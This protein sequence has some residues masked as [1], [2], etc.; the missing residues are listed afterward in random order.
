LTATGVLTPAG[1]Q[2]APQPIS[3][4]TLDTITVTPTKTPE[5]IWDSLSSTSA[6]RQDKI[7]QLMPNRTSDLLFGLP[8]VTQVTRGDD[9]ATAINIRGL[10]DFGRVAVVVDGARQNFQRSGHNANG[11]FYL[12][13]ELISGLDITRGPVANIYG[14]GAIGG[15]AS[16]TTKDANDILKPGERW[17]I[18]TH[19]LGGTNGPLGLSSVFAAARPNE[20]VDIFAGGT[21][22]SS[23]DY[24]DGHGDTVANTG[25][26]IWTGIGKITV[27]PADG[28]EVKLGA[29]HYD[30]DY[31]TGQSGVSG[32]YG[33]NVKN[34]QL[35]GKYT[36][37]PTGQSLIDLAT[38]I[39]FNRSSTDQTVKEQFISGGID[40]TGPVGTRRNF[41]IDTKGFDI[42]NTSRFDWGPFR[43][44]LTVGGDGFRD[45]VSISSTGDPGSALTPG[46]TRKVS[47]AFVQWKANYSTWLE[48]IGALRYDNYSLDGGGTHTDG[49]RL[50]PKIT[51][52]V[53]PIAGFQPYV[54]YAEGYRAPA[55]TETLVVGY[56]PGDLFYF[57]P[58]PNLRPEI[59]KT[60]EAGVNLKYDNLF[61][62][63]DKFRGKI[64]IFRNNVEDYIDLTSF[65]YFG[66]PPAPCPPSSIFGGAGSLCFQY[67]NVPRA[68]VEGIEFE[69]M[70][71]AGRW[72][73][74]LAGQH[75]K[76][77]NLTNSE[78]LA[79]IQPDSLTTTLGA[80]F[81]DRKLTVAMRWMAVAPKR[82]GDI[83]VDTNQPGNP[84][85]FPTS[86][87]YNL[88][89]LY[90]GYEPKPD[91]QLGFSIDNLLDE[92]YTPYMNQLSEPGIT[93]KGELKVRFSDA[94]FKK[95]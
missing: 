3:T 36:Y 47:G 82:A 19:G 17:A 59:G 37:A 28:H 83:P 35:T 63:G 27:R 60:S 67:T 71:D 61:T 5:N 79:T 87:A 49:D 56:H 24:R 20:N 73:A 54:T 4:I 22:R 86:D 34:D 30:A 26:D 39:Y 6:V 8:S 78:P 21:Y 43:N 88:V 90:V 69:T 55:V 66:P 77:R 72:F 12:E 23:G 91:V 76:G 84:L 10:Q 57:L 1:A 14:S 75:L 68:R 89:K 50:S 58:N 65:A 2:D 94:Y 41:T 13:P 80:R 11:M 81:L 15:V 51:V 92:K 64:S 85:V 53:T 52:G 25:Q 95:G 44:A 74:G 9:P 45:D 38:S 32:V 33:T 18:Q 31:T 62:A 70:Y 16:F 7:D 48:A 46:G 29:I 42:N 93:F 40:F